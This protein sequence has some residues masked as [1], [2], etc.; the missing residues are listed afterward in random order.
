M[1]QQEEALL[2][3]ILHN[4]YLQWRFINA[5]ADAALQSQRA[6]AEVRIQQ[7]IK[8]SCMRPNN[9]KRNAEWSLTGFPRSQF[10]FAEIFVQCL[11]ENFRVA[12]FSSDTTNEVATSQAFPQA[13]KDSF[14]S[15]E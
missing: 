14:I 13:E 5:R 7:W 1:S 11:V 12:S 15:G 9:M 8:V 3:R 6:T 4:R 10:T 2:L